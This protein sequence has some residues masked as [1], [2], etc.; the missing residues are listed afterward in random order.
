[1]NT[2]IASASLREKLLLVLENETDSLKCAVA[3]EA[4][5]QDASEITSFFSGLLQ[6]GCISGMVGSLIYYCDTHAFYDKHYDQIEE[7]R[8]DHESSIGQPIK[9]DSDYKNFMAWFAFEKT[10]YQLANELGLEI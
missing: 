8:L 10:A 7:L 6:Y 4:L 1:M 9:V 2:S 5:D 3:Q